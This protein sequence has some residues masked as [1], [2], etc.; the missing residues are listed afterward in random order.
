MRIQGLRF[1]PIEKAVHICVDMQRLFAE[2]TEWASPAVNE[3]AP[4]V[5]RVC[6]R[7]PA[8]TIFTRFLTP[9]RVEDAKGQWQVYYRRWNCVLASR[10]D[11]DIF[12]LLP[13]LRRFTPPARVIDKHSYSGFENAALQKALDQFGAKTVVLT[14]VETEVCLLATALTAIDRGYRTILVSDAIASAVPSS[15]RACLESIFTR[16]DEQVE[17]VDGAAVLAAWNP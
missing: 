6:E 13:V 7:S 10:L 11:P 1:G 12:G 4:A 3:I 9:D 14:G 17:L 2:D 15:H 16:Y 8:H 5:A